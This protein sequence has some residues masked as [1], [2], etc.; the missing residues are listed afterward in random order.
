M[1]ELIEWSLQH[2]SIS[3]FNFNNFYFL[4]LLSV[5]CVCLSL[6]FCFYVSQFVCLHLSVFLSLS[7]F[8]WLCVFSFH[9]IF[10][11]SLCLSV[12]L[13]VCL[14]PFFCFSVSRFVCLYL[15]LCMFS[16]SLSFVCLYLQSSFFAVC[17]HSWIFFGFFVN[18]KLVFL[19]TIFCL[20]ICTHANPS[21]FLSPGLCTYLY[22]K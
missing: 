14:S 16:S 17:Q 2:L 8:V 15:A 12:C 5:C 10:I 4:D 18:L 13:S 22:L 20:I 6:S 3:I 11:L 7:L 21:I 9:Y 19:S 1:K